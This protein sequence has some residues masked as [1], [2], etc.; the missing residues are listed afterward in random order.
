MTRDSK[1]KE[2]TSD[3]ALAQEIAELERQ[4]AAAKTR[5]RERNIA[6]SDDQKE[7]ETLTVNGKDQSS[8]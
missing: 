1:P 8:E 7:P 4:L 5:A 2:P 3:E 6:I